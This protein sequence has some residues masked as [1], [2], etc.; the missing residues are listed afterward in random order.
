[1]LCTVNVGVLCNKL[2]VNCPLFK[3][4]SSCSNGCPNREKLF[5]LLNTAINS[6]IQQDFEAIENNIIIKGP[7]HCCQ[8]NC[9]GLEITTFSHIGKYNLKQHLYSWYN[10]ILICYNYILIF[11]FVIIILNILY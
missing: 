7:R 2:F 10:Y 9:N 8:Q 4:V 3:E 1:M 6:F 5:P 11:I